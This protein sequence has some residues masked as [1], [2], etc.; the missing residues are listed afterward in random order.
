MRF[1]NQ[2]KTFLRILDTYQDGLSLAKFLQGF[3]RANRQ[4]GSNDRRTAGR[5]VYSYFRMGKASADLPAEECLFLGEFLCSNSANPFLEYFKPELHQ[6]IE[7]PLPEKISL[8]EKGD[9]G[10]KLDDV[11]PFHQHLSEGI[12]KDE[13]IKSFF[14]QPDVFI[15]VHPRKEKLVKAKLAEEG[16]DFLEE[17]GSA[18]RLPAAVKLDQ[19]FPNDRPFEVQDI[20]SQETGQFFEAESGDYWWDCCAASGGKSLL[21][22]QQQPDVKLLVS[23]I[24][25]S[26]LKNLDERFAADGL[27]NYQKKILDLT[28]DQEQVLHSFQ[29][30]G[31]IFDAPCSGSG[32]WG[33]SPEQI[34]Q[35]SESRITAFQRLQRSIA[36]NVLPY[37]KPGKP[38]TYITCSVFKEENEENI[39]FFIKE[40]GL[41]LEKQEVLRGYNRKSDTMFAARLIK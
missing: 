9:Y 24:R 25:E 4:M 12:E 21:L 37:L 41:K 19:I 29:F 34:S 30:D 13:F 17:S 40:L 3:F 7:L 5:L 28:L 14:I 15:R 35:F 39:E 1:E 8:L 10:F 16:I 2:L 20:S 23:D 32:T 36:K 6:K 38:L 33:R 22:A 31:I 11:F 18:L 26:V 27:K